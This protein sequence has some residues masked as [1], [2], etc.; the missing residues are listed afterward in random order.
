MVLQRRHLQPGLHVSNF[1]LERL[2]ISFAFA[3]L[4]ANI[5]FFLVPN[6]RPAGMNAQPNSPLAPSTGNVDTLHRER[7]ELFELT[8]K[9]PGLASFPRALGPVEASPQTHDFLKVCA[10]S[11]ARRERQE[12]AELRANLEKVSVFSAFACACLPSCS[13]WPLL[14]LKLAPPC[15]SEKSSD[16]S[17]QTSC[18]PLRK[19]SVPTPATA[20]GKAAQGAPRNTALARRR[21]SAREKQRLFGLQSSSSDAPRSRKSKSDGTQRSWARSQRST[22]GNGNTSRKVPTPR[23]SRAGRAPRSLRGTTGRARQ[24][25]RATSGTRAGTI[26]QRRAR[27]AP[28]LL[29]VRVRTYGPR[30][31]CVTLAPL[32]LRAQIGASVA[33]CSVIWDAT[34]LIGNPFAVPGVTDNMVCGALAGAVAFAL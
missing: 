11:Q 32:A 4:T 24:K 3:S 30:V 16:W 5:L 8:E 12:L 22:T 9:V 29:R 25:A 10:P 14:V 34:A 1:T 6:A 17:E 27:S 28:A 18:A 13:F 21:P 33:L 26:L 20:R 7:R 2:L 19:A 15:R 23:A 31:G